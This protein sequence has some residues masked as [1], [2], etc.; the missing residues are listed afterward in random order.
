MKSLKN[1]ISGFTRNHISRH[2][3]LLSCPSMLEAVKSTSAACRRS[4]ALPMSAI[5]MRYAGLCRRTCCA[6]P[7]DPQ[8]TLLIIYK[9]VHFSCQRIFTITVFSVLVGSALLLLVEKSYSG[10][11]ISF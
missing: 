8:S 7:I 1:T 3:V 6:A 9:T 10:I 4:R 11:M 2:E 5:N